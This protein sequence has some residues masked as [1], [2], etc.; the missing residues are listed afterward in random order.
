M[1][2]HGDKSKNVDDRAQPGHDDVIAYRDDNALPIDD[3]LL[4]ARARN[5]NHDVVLAFVIGKDQVTMVGFAPEHPGA[6][7]AASPGFA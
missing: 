6:A 7:G 3:D 4:A 2:C 1:S 5:A